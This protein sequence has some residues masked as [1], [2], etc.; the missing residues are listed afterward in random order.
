MRLQEIMSTNV[1]TAA[2]GESASVAWARMQRRRIRHL[3][4]AEGKR[5]LG[6][7]SDRD[8]GGPNGSVV[9]RGHTVEELM[10]PRPVSASPET[11]IRQA[12][13]LMRGHVIGSLPV[14]DRDRLVGIVTATDV[15]DELGRG[16]TR[17]VVRGK[18][19][20]LRLPA[21]QR[22]RGGRKLP[23]ANAGPQQEKPAPRSS[24]PSLRR[25]VRGRLTKP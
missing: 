2:P 23:P 7:L 21:G 14:V 9:R 12:A 13:N 17:P 15:L 16:H 1:V 3:V 24:R 8:L 22:W 18:R 20:P 10:T 5:I 19:P 25:R 11:T 6:M 4:V